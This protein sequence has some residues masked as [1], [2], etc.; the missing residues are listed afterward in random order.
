VSRWGRFLDADEGAHYEFICKRAGVQVR[1][2]AEQFENDNSPTSNLLKA[3]KRMMAGEYSRELS[4]KVLAGQRRLVEL[5]FRMGGSA[6]LGMQRQLLDKEGKR[7]RILG[8][9]ERKGLTDRVILIPGPQTDVDAV[10]EIFRLFTTRYKTI[11]QLRKYLNG[12]HSPYPERHW[13][14]STL[15][16][17]LMNP[18][19][20]GTNVFHRETLA[21]KGCNPP[22]EWFV[23]ERA[24]QPIIEAKR[25][26]AAQKLL[27]SPTRRSSEQ[28]LEDLRR[29]WRRKGT[30][31]AALIAQAKDMACQGTYTKVFGSLGQ[32]YELIGFSFKN[33]NPGVSARHLHRIREE[34]RREIF[35]RVMALGGTLT[36]PTM[37][38][39]HLL[40]NDQLTVRLAFSPARR[41]H[42]GE[43][44]WKLYFKR[45]CSDVTIVAR[46][47][48]TNAKVLDYYVVPR[49]AELFGT[50]R[51][52]ETD[53]KGYITVYRSND[54][55]AFFAALK[56]CRVPEAM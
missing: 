5:G 2:C 9:G 44:H 15:E 42:S 18:V 51:V 46:L 55:E 1:Y 49:I 29:L 11:G 34:L 36:L 23:R 7:R 31:S 22:E 50:T 13:Q 45:D 37:R 47:D 30:I 6:P 39:R 26:T 20:I 33:Q 4:V 19:Y 17:I 40:V 8:P 41:D 16:Y 28:M 52:R 3:L 24:F 14:Q 32:A 56:C 25:F 43:T 54:L 38:Q 53:N 10:R 12:P 35:D 21:K 27:R 48:S